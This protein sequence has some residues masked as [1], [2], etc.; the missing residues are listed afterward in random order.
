M[1]HSPSGKAIQDVGVTPQTLLP[2]PESQVE[3]DDD[4]NPLTPANDAA[5]KKDP[6]AD[7]NYLKRVVESWKN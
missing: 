7:A 5:P 4:G 6:N 2:E 3:L 1:V